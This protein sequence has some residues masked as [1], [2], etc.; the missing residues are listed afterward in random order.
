MSLISSKQAFEDNMSELQVLVN[1]C[2]SHEIK[3]VC[4]QRS[5]TISILQASS[6]TTARL[7]SLSQIQ[8]S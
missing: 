4:A 7:A 8:V 2:E 5:S 6:M 1:C 3:T